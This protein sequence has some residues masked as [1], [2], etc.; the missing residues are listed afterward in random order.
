LLKAAGATSVDALS[1]AFRE[2][3]DLPTTALARIWLGDESG[4][5]LVA[6]TGRPIGGGSYHHV[7]GAHAVF[8]DGAGKITR[9]WSTGECLMARGLRGDEP[10]LENPGWA[11][12]QGIRSFV[13]LPIAADGRV[14][15]VLALFDRVLTSDESVQ[16]LRFFADVLAVRF[17]SM[18]EPASSVASIVTRQQLRAIEKRS[19]QAALDTCGGRVFGP[20]GAAVLLGMRPTTLASRMKA[21]GL[22]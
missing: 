17:T 10:W 4:L 6:S 2:A 21:L 20:N 15:G 16:E 9:I 22:K 8:R 7:D 19:L 5:R 12:R 14:L 1:A 18:R 13:G 3:L 11:A